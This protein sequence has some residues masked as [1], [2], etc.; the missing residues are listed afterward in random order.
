MDWKRHDDGYRI[1]KDK[2]SYVENNNMVPSVDVF[3][4]N[5]NENKA[6]K[7]SDYVDAG[8]IFKKF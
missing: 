1:D 5:Q 2:R 8:K 6:A 7:D 3:L 4:Q